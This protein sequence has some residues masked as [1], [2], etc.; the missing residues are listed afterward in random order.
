MPLTEESTNKYIIGKCQCNCDI[1]LVGEEA[2]YTCESYPC[3]PM[4]E[5]KDDPKKT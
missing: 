3:Y 2:Q 5:E 4:E 1:W